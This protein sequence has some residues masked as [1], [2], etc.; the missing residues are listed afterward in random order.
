MPIGSRNYRTDVSHG[1]RC[2]QET[3]RARQDAH[4]RRAISSMRCAVDHR[5]PVTY[6]HL[7]SLGRDYFAKKKQTTEA[8]FADL[9]MIGAIAKTMTRP[10]EHGDRRQGQARQARSLNADYRK[11]EL[12]RITMANHALLERLENLKPVYKV[13]D[14]IAQYNAT[15]EAVANASHT[16]RKAGL[17]DDLLSAKSRRVKPRSLPK[18]QSLPAIRESGSVLQAQAQLESS[19]KQAQL[20]ASRGSGSNIL[21]NS[22]SK[23]LAHS[24]PPALSSHGSG[25]VNAKPLSLESEARDV[26][27]ALMLAV[28]DA[29][30]MV[31]SKASML[32][33][34]AQS[35]AVV[36]V[37]A[38]ADSR[39]AAGESY[40]DA[41]DGVDESVT[42][43]EEEEEE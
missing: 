7:T 20:E 22:S 15:R 6:P 5:P 10:T 34:D 36:E 1:N 27:P 9:K 33:I 25:P 35:A 38:Q 21:G 19:D 16:A 32:P 26:M 11:K 13:R 14:Q 37:T 29:E 41:F 2:V 31:E 30:P 42:E 43:K 40:A 12:F 18:V 8:A 28:T 4:L 3:E 17:Y 39:S 24:S 23:P